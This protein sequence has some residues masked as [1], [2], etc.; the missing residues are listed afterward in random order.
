MS[1]EARAVGINHTGVSVDSID[2]SLLFY[3]D[4]LGLELVLDLDVDHHPGLEEVVAMSDVV[5]RCVFLD[6]GDTRLELWEYRSPAGQPIRD[7]HIPA[8]R[9]VTHVA[10]TV[11]DVDAMY[12]HLTEAGVECLSKPLDLGL[13]KTMYVKGP[14]NEFVELLE[15]RTDLAMLGRITRRTLAARA[16]A[17]G[18]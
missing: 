14:D 12:L 4:L 5:G 8:D 11:D 7:G 3:R 6:A 10:F 9:G 13:H 1:P 2:R 18:G 17:S 15:D 16:A